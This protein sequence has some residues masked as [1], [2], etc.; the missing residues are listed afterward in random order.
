MTGPQ[1]LADPQPLA[2]PHPPA[3]PQPLADPGPPLGQ[4]PTSP[5]VRSSARVIELSGHD[6]PHRWRFRWAPSER[7]AEGAFWQPGFDDSAWGGMLVP[8]SF[9]MP[10]LDEVAGGPHGR[11]AYT[12][13]RY[14]FPLDPPHP[15]D[16]NP[17]GD[18]R[19]RFVLDRV[20]AGARLR[21]DG[22]EGAGTVWLNGRLLGSTRG[23]RLPAE[24]DV[25]GLLAA[26]NVLAVRVHTFS[27]ASY[28][29]DQDEWWAP[30]IIRA[31]TLRERPAAA[32]DA[33]RVRADWTGEAGT[34]LVEVDSGTGDGGTS[35]GGAGDGE[36]AG[37]AV[38]LLEPGLDIVPG[39][40]TRVPGVSPW[41]AESPTLYTLRVTTPGESVE[42]RIGFRTVDIVDGVFRVNGSPVRF[43]GVNRHEHHPRFG[44][45]VP[46]A[47]LRQELLLM[48]RS[49]VNAIR[50]SHYPP[51]PAM[52][53]LADEL[54]L[55][56]LDECDVETHGFGEAGWRRNPIDDPLW[57]P[58]L[59]DRAARMVERDRN[60]PSVVLWSLGNEAGVGRNLAAMAEEIRRRDPSRPLHYEG[61]QSCAEV[62]LWSRMY[63]SHAELA[64][65]ARR[66]EPALADAR[67]DARR[68][69][70]PFLQCEYAH[71]MGTGP[72]GLEE[73]QEL[74]DSA[75]RMMGGFVW[76]WLEHGVETTLD[77]RPAT[78][79]GGDFGEVVHDGNFVIDGLVAA[80]RT[81]R[82]QL[83]DLAQ[84]FAPVVLRP[85]LLGTAGGRLEVRSRLDHVDT[86]HLALRW[87]IERDA[88]VVAAGEL[89]A[90]PVPPRGTVELDWPA[91]VRAALAE[92]GSVVVIEAVDRHPRPWAPADAVLVRAALDTLE[93]ATARPTAVP[94]PPALGLADLRLD[95]ATGAVTALGG[96]AVE[97]WRLELWRAPTDNDR[98]VASDRPG[99][100]AAAER[101]AALGLD[102]LVSRLLGVE[103]DGRRIV[104]RSRVGGAGSDAT[105]DMSCTWT[106]VDGAL[107]LELALE[108][109]VGVPAEWARA[110]LSFALPAAPERVAWQG[111][112]PGPAY[113][114]TGQA[115]LPGWFAASLEELQERTVRPQESGSRAG[116][117]WLRLEGDG[118]AL[119]VAAD[120][121]IAVT[122]RPWATEH[123]AAV[124]HD[125]R[126]EPDGRT[127]LVL[128]L[129]QQ[130]VGSAACGPGP[131]PAHRLDAR[132]LRARLAFRAR[133]QPPAPESPAPHERRRA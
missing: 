47:V 87:R 66:E 12:N 74:F 5:T 126:L 1:P 70:M 32:V 57:E 38:R 97:D 40:P 96:L 101:W 25:S 133:A 79:Y 67:L 118:G 115:A 77:G 64:L 125:H 22:V 19:L 119:E 90:P 27:A 68:R 46:A 41:S 85:V 89:P 80:D 60:H 93:A 94:V 84:T 52:L 39:T 17:V 99:L 121:A 123:I 31:V 120:P 114:D 107:L 18:Y 23:S 73:Y 14:P 117:R 72:G 98:G 111:R 53:E 129:A 50:T 105:V 7:E 108:P 21:F 131:L 51:D 55:W 11:P 37:I 8:A 116:V 106:A 75:D 49:N 61:D 127:H 4:L 100:P 28:L 42:L 112:G 35:D 124:D 65:I 16:A 122:V 29:E 43:R 13:V 20:P 102:R 24:F 104:V 36:A 33:V 92:A 6:G 56:V 83:A 86:A 130:G 58:A 2:G 15:P 132:P 54:G 69:A 81:P 44:R 10:A 48:K 45:H 103:R 71:A 78:G 59:R 30:G 26:E 34:L 62:D 9:V 91:A 110:G 128:D 3:G 95:P 88:T 76:E 113:P 63:A 109:A 82:A